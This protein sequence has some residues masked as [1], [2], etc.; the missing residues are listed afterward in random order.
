MTTI[1]ISQSPEK[2]G[3][4]YCIQAATPEFKAYQEQVLSNSAR[5]AKVSVNSTDAMV[6]GT[7]YMRTWFLHWKHQR[8]WTENCYW[9]NITVDTKVV[10]V[11]IHWRLFL[12]FWMHNL[13]KCYKFKMTVAH[14]IWCYQCSLLTCCYTKSSDTRAFLVL[15]AMMSFISSNV[16]LLIQ[17][18]FKT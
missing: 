4:D 18:V 1:T 2:I 5:F 11:S 17:L 10:R 6:Q 3:T 12:L 14:I 9:F 16:N 15:S 8:V 13:L 7:Q